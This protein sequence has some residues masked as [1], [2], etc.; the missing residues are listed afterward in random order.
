MSK[1]PNVYDVG[2][3]VLVRRGSKKPG[4]KILVPAWYGPFIVKAEDHPRY[5]LR[6]DDSRRF[7]RPVHA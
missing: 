3:M 2:E 7:R 6:T 5:T 4:S 1:W